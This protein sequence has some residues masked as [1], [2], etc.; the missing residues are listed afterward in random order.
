M[1]YNCL[2]CIRLVSDG[3]S[4]CSCVRLLCSDFWQRWTHSRSSLYW[5]GGGIGKPFYDLLFL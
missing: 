4:N 2:A 1:A 3:S 5:T